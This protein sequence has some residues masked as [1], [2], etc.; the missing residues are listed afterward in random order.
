M[1]NFIVLLTGN[2]TQL[3]TYSLTGISAGQTHAL[4]LSMTG[5]NILVY[6]DNSPVINVTPTGADIVSDVG[7]AA[8]YS[9]SASSD[10]TGLHMDNFLATD[11]TPQALT[12][13]TLSESSHTS[14]SATV[15]W[16]SASGGTAPITFQLQRSA[17]GAATWS[18]VNGATSSPA[19]DTG[20]SSAASYDYRVAY[21]DAAPTT[22]YS[23]TLTVTTDVATTTYTVQQADLWDNGYDNVAAPRQSNF[24]RFV[25]TTDAASVTISGTTT[26]YNNYPQYAHLGVSINGVNQSSLVFTANGSQN[27]S[28][29]LG[30]AGTTRTVEV[31]SGLQSKPGG[32][33]LGSF[34]DSVTYAQT[35]NFNVST[36]TT[37]N[38]VLVYGDSIAVGGNATNTEYNGYVPLLRNTYGYRVMLEGWGYRTLY[39]DINTAPLR[40]TFVSRLAGYSPSVIWIA[41][42]TNDY[43]LN[44]WSA[45]NFGTAY[46]ALLDDLHTAIPSVKIFCQ[47]PIVRVNEGANSFGNTTGDYRS[48]ILTVC[49]ARSSF[50]T[51]VDGSTLLTTSD[52]DDNVHPS[53]SGH[54]K[55]AKRIA[56]YLSSPSFTISGPSLG[57]NSQASTAFTVT[58]ASASFF[59]DQTITIAASSGT[60]TATAVGGSITN[61]GTGSVVVTPANTVT[62]FAFTYTPLSEGANTL[63]FTNGQGWTSPG[64]ASYTADSTAPTV[65]S[66]SS[67]T[68][69]STGATITWTTNENTSSKVDYGLTN[70]YGSSTTET[71]TT[72]RVTSHS[73]SLS[74]LVA[75]TTY[76]FRVRST[77][78]ALNA[79]IDSD[80]T[81]TTSGCTTSAQATATNSAQITTAGGGSLTL[82]DNNS[83]G[84]T[85]TVPTSFAASDANF[86]AHQLDKTTVLATTSTPTG[87]SAVGN[88]VYEL[89]A[90]SDPSTK[91]SAFDKSLTVAMAY[92]SSDVSGV[93]ESTLNI[94]RW[95]GSG[96]NQLSG[97]SV[98]T[99]AKTVGCTTTNFS[100]F[101]LFGQA[102]SSG[103]SSSSTGNSSPS[104]PACG[105]QAPGSAPWLYAAIPQDANSI[106]LYFTDVGDAADK[107]ALAFGLRSGGEQYGQDNIGGKGLRTYLVQ[108]L[109]PSTT[110]YFKVRGGH[111][112]A[113]GPWSNEI[114]A[115]TKGLLVAHP[116]DI[117]SSELTPVPQAEPEQP[118]PSDNCQRYTVRSGD[119]LWS[120]A[121]SQLGNGAK[122]Q[123]IIDQNKN[124]YPA[125]S[126]NTLGVGWDLILNCD[127]TNPP[128]IPE[129][130]GY[131]V[132]VKVTDTQ[133]KPIVGAQV[134]LHSTPQT[135]TTDNN[136]FASF[137]GVE[138]GEHRVIISYN[139]YQGEQSINLT[140][141]VKEFDLAVQVQPA[142]PFLARPVILVIGLL[143]ACVAALGVGLIKS[144]KAQP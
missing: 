33:V 91:I 108:S 140:G 65:T 46:A 127:K 103:S 9:N 4:K 12:A 3:A 29:T 114:S 25:F 77:D 59:G 133:K 137:I 123:E 135:T 49:N 124:A 61:N 109:A 39:S 111:G 79:T 143:L 100:V 129:T 17:H 42:G 32:S 63:T 102:A 71:D 112:C 107:Y 44:S 55:Y 85:L 134:T 1:G 31:T 86:Q 54:A 80:S 118:T 97:C 113:T 36:P 106:L 2:G 10:S 23:N 72:T 34:I 58:I 130:S 16:I 47:S 90:L 99:L 13:G 75:C 8:V 98:D 30:T 142:N 28:V 62:N 67:G 89:S 144:R 53:T 5:N 126:A 117:V 125:I 22:V 11:P 27:F 121:Q 14:N 41:I 21:T 57:Q 128:P 87:Y 19:T 136:G 105:D 48:Q 7:L 68:P 120:V 66:V 83:H 15:T 69:T 119:T 141:E 115:T 56:P 82:Q 70:S 94:Y 96:W 51:Y 116:L 6:W 138:P 93:D 122:F 26:I 37:G 101:A 35:S 40:S 110:Y 18:N 50:T 88:Y 60:L 92:G 38:R 64:A 45:A 20:L 84:L 78:S 131:Q 95:D 24:A 104:A 73:I 43:A 52:L 81:F 132:K 139:N 74:S 76:H